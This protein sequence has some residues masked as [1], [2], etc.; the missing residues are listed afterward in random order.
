MSGDSGQVVEAAAPA[1]RLN[2][3]TYESTFEV[4][5]PSTGRLGVAFR[6]SSECWTVTPGGTLHKLGV[7]PGCLLLRANGRPCGATD[8]AA[9]AALAAAASDG[10][11]SRVLTF[12]RPSPPQVP[13]ECRA[14]RRSPPSELNGDDGRG[15]RSRSSVTTM[16]GR[17]V[18]VKTLRP[19]ATAT[20]ARDLL[21][22]AALL[23]RLAPH[24]HVAR[25][26]AWSLPDSPPWAAVAHIPGQDLK[27]YLR[28]ESGERMGAAR[29]THDTAL[30]VAR[31]VAA[32]LAHC[33]FT[34]ALGGPVLLH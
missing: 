4:E 9:L 31:H 13:G 16:D 30:E 34:E 20:E 25:L 17:D 8:D 1:A 27:S 29:W 21:R 22:E 2:L 3:D 26:V 14:P 6:G 12:A 5:A 32:A 28:D 18:F 23:A 10:R 24:P 7:Y 15:V 33:H 11:E 19:Q